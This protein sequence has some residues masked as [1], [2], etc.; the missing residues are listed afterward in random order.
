MTTA[1]NLLVDML[2]GLSCHR[3]G[4]V[5]TRTSIHSLPGYPDLSE[6]GKLLE[7]KLRP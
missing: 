6:R 1:Q 5:Q 7:A 4:Y 3:T 2:L